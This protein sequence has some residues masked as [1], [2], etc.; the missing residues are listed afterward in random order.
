MALKN[1]PYFNNQLIHGRA[2]PTQLWSDEPSNR[3]PENNTHAL[4]NPERGSRVGPL[5]L[6]EEIPDQRIEHRDS[7]ANGNASQRSEEQQVLQEK[8]YV[9]LSLPL[10]D[11]KHLNEPSTL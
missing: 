8:V 5:L 11:K 1:T 6:W 3:L 2:P 9:I 10:I 7:A 4:R